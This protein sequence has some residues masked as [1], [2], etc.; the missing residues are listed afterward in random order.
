MLVIIQQF[1]HPL[2]L[3]A[4][5]PLRHLNAGKLAERLLKL[6]IPNLLVW[7][8][9]FYSLFHC[10]LNILAEVTFFGDRLFYKAWWNSSTL[11]EYV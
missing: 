7:L 8:C 2:L 6:A 3:N 5:E 10:W 1:I 11:S 4:R 9:M